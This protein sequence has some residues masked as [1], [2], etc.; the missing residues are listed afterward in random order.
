[1]Q[2][3]HA[4]SSPHLLSVKETA[5]FLRVSKSWLDKSRL[6][7]TGPRHVKIGASVRYDLDDL[8]SYIAARKRSSTSALFGVEQD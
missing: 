7:G 5:A 1:M 6:A 4:V 8:H 2:A 3:K